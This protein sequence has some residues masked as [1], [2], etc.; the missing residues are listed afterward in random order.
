MIGPDP[1][2]AQRYVNAL[3]LAFFQVYANH[4]APFRTYLQAS[5][6]RSLSDAAMPLLFVRSFS[7]QD[8]GAAIA[9]INR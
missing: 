4:Q 8:L 3:S 5:Y 1:L 9:Q 2:V 6:A 7:P